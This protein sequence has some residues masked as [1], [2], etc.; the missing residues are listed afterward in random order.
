MDCRHEWQYF[1]CAGRAARLPF[2]KVEIT[3]MTD[4]IER[5]VALNAP[6]ETVWRALADSKEF[7]EWFRV[8]LEGPFAPGNA[9]SGHITHPGYEHI[10]WNAV[11][12][13]MDEPRLFSFTWHP[14]A[15]EPGVDYSGEEPT[16]VE[17]R[18]EPVAGGTLLTLVETGFDAVPEQRRAKA[19]EMH[20]NGWTEQMK[21]IKAHVGRRHEGK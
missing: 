14:Y 11:I 18:L 6:I 15:V 7:S 1:G 13:K 8:K 3:I 10:K 5:S 12:Q 16:L 17:F 20:E 9:A 19:F 4:R 2:G 21:N